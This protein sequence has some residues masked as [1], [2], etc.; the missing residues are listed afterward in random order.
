MAG[1]RVLLC[2]GALLARQGSAGLRL[3]LNPSRANLSVGPN[4]EVLPG[5]HPDLEAVAIGEVHDNV[6]LHCG[7]VS[8]SRGLVTWYR[9]DSEP[10]FLVS[11]NSSLPPAAPRF[12]LEDAGALRIEALRLEDD[13]NYTCQEVLN[14]THWFPV[15]LRVASGPAYVEVNISAT[16]TL[17]NGTLYAARGS[18]V[19]FNCCSAAQPPPE[20]EWWIQTQ[21]IP[22]FL[23]KN[24]SANSFTLMLMSQNLQGN[25]TC[26][27]TNVLSGRQRKVTTELLVYWPPPSAPQCSVEVSSESTTLELACNWDGGYPDPTFL[28][29]EE[30][31]G[32]IMGNS[33]LQTLSPAQLSEGKKFK[34]V[35]NH[36][37]GPES[38][39]SC[40]VQISS[41][42]LP[43]QPM[44]TCFMGGN[45]TLTCEVSGA[46][47]PARI[48]WLRN[49][50][51]PAIQPSSHY[52]ITQ[53]GQSSSLTIHNCS[54]DLDEGFYY[55][56]AENLVGVRA[57]NIWLSVK[58]PLNIGGIVGTVVSLLL[59][60]LAVVSGLMLYYSPAFWWK[61]GSTFRGQDMGDVMVLVDSEEEEE[62]EEEKE[63]EKEDVAEE[64]EQE[65]NETEELPKGISKHGRIHRVTALVNGNLDH[66]GNGFQEFQDDSDGQQSGIVQEDD[67]PV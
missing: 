56:R 12:S 66:M 20:V 3:L 57:A 1:L 64:V 52:I 41:P 42:L 2:L 22:E 14:E 60:G 7:S 47:P 23:G 28:W 30:P 59:L 32:T 16:G 27:A 49:L 6:T 13:G 9:N 21:G 33:K 35:G 53:Q 39:A 10:A 63:E 24:L 19:D 40:V 26:S 61:G 54:Q 38:G 4:S 29:T 5:I 44:R 25:Y 31:G 65:T 43:S 36:I 45:V 51:Q 58:E 37:L 50:T 15:Q 34:C 62:E 67:K 18:Q 46:N 48:Q 55:C 8:G 11:S 17:P